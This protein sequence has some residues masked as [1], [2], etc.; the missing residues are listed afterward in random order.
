MNAR[1]CDRRSAMNRRQR[2]RSMTLASALSPPFLCQAEKR[3]LVKAFG[4]VSTSES[5]L[6]IIR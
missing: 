2:K 6:G 4:S 3:W 1:R 5:D